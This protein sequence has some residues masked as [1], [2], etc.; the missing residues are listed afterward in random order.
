M[1]VGFEAEAATP[2]TTFNAKITA[3]KVSVIMSALSRPYSFSCC[4]VYWKDVFS[5]S[6]LKRS[7]FMLASR[8]AS[9]YSHRFFSVVTK[10]PVGRAGHY[11]VDAVRWPGMHDLGA[12]ADYDLI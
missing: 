12:V 7:P 11:E 9:P 1:G 3:L 10:S 4:F 5:F 6:P 2:C 8:E